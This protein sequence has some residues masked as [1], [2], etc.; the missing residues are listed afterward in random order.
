MGFLSR[1]F[2]GQ[3]AQI[4]DAE[5]IYQTLLKQSRST[6]FYGAGRVPDTYDG[7]VD[8]LTLHLA[9]VFQVLRKY[10]DSSHS[11][12]GVLLSQA[13]FDVMR[14]DFDIALREEGLSDKGVSRRIKPII[15]LF[16]TRLKVYD[17]ALTETDS[18]GAFQTA[19]AAGLLKDSPKAFIDHIAQYTLDFSARLQGRSLSDIAKAK[20]E[21]NS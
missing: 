13:I 11:K 16:Y 4:L 9:P 1:I 10:E 5:R 6:E 17:D 8:F 3:P 14:D 15:E 19:L 7:R 21:F 2:G 20:F 12:N 18:L